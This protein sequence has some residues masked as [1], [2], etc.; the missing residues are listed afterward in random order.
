MTLVAYQ[1]AAAHVSRCPQCETEVNQQRAARPWLR[2]AKERALVEAA[3]DRIEAFLV[4]R[5]GAPAGA[6]PAAGSPR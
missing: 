5:L 2:M 1:R 3:L 6:A 4:A